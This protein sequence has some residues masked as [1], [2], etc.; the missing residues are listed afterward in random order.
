MEDHD[1]SWSPNGKKIAYTHY[2]DSD[3]PNEAAAVYKIA[4]EGEVRSWSPTTT[5]PAP[6]ILPGEPSIVASPPL[7]RRGSGSLAVSALLLV[8]IHPSAWQ[9]NSPKFRHPGCLCARTT[10]WQGYNLVCDLD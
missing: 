4:P 6:S 7:S 3:L 8:P 10:R 1:P 9:E 5:A 2:S